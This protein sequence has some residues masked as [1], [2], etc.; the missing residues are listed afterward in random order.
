MGLFTKTKKD[1]VFSQVG[2]GVK[3]GKNSP[4][5]T[6]AVIGAFA[7][8]GRNVEIGDWAEIGFSSIVENNVKIGSHVKIGR[9]AHIGKGAILPDNVHVQPG[10]VV[11][12]GTQFEGHELVTKDGII[13]NRCSGFVY[14]HDETDQS[15]VVE[16]STYFAR[17]EVPGDV[18]R[19][20]MID[21]YMFG[22]DEL[23]K[24]RI[25]R[26]EAVAEPV[27]EINTPEM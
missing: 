16:I 17:F 11:P 10:V 8:I 3:I 19:E 26:P 9:D 13:P 5:G 22:S 18:F 27:E 20:E 14:Y 24:Y 4:V 25:E 6:W 15:K 7:T 12:A 1:G 23:D 2:G 21:E